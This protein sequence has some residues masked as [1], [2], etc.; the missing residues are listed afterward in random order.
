MNQPDNTTSLSQQAGRALTMLDGETTP[1]RS[2]QRSTLWVRALERL[3][4]GEAP[5]TP[6]E[7]RIARFL[8]LLQAS[9]VA[10]P[11]ADEQAEPAVVIGR[12]ASPD[13][14]SGP[15]GLWRE[16]T[17]F[18]RDERDW[19][20]QHIATLDE[21][22]D[23]VLRQLADP[24]QPMAAQTRGLV[25]GHIQ[26]GKTAHFTGLIAKAVDSGYRLVIVLTGALNLRRFQVQ[27]E[28]E[29][30]LWRG[31][32]SSG[33]GSA[34]AHPRDVA[35]RL[36][37]GVMRVTTLD[38]DYRATDGGPSPWEFIKTDPDQPLYAPRNLEH[39]PVRLLAVKKNAAVLSKIM[40]DLQ[41]SEC[42]LPELPALVIDD[43][44]TGAVPLAG[45]KD[46]G[47]CGAD[48][49]L[50]ELIALLPR[51]QY[52]KFSSTPFVR[53]LLDPGAEEELFPRDYVVCLPQP[54]AEPSSQKTNRA[55]LRVSELP[56]FWAHDPGTLIETEGQGS[57]AFELLGQ[58]VDMFVLT[59]ALKLYRQ[60][61]GP[62]VYR[63]H[64][65]LVH[66]GDRLVDQHQILGRL[67][68]QWDPAAF[69]R[70]DSRARLK[71]LF[72]RDILKQTTASLEGHHTPEAFEDL[73]PYIRAA[74]GRM[75]RAPQL[76]TGSD[77]GWRALQEDFE[78]REVW[79]IVIAG[80]KIARELSPAGLTVTF[81]YAQGSRAAN[82][83]MLNQWFGDLPGY[84]DLVR[85]YLGHSSD[86]AELVQQAGWALD[87]ARAEETFRAQLREISVDS[88]NSPLKPA[89]LPALAAQHLP[90]R[91][92]TRR[93]RLFNAE[94]VEIRSP[95]R[96]VE[97]LARPARAA[98]RAHNARVWGPLQQM[99]CDDV[100]SLVSS[101]FGTRQADAGFQA[102]AGVV[103]H[104]QLLDVFERL[105]WQRPE[106]FRPYLQYLRSLR[107]KLDDWAVFWPQETAENTLA[108]TQDSAMSSHIAPRRSELLA[109]PIQ[110]SRRHRRLGE[111]IVGMDRLGETSVP[112]RGVLFLY[113]MAETNLSR[114]QRTVRPEEF[115]MGVSY[116]VPD[117]GSS[118]IVRFK[119]RN[120]AQA[121][122]PILAL[123]R[124]QKECI[125]PS[126]LSA[127]V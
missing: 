71:A 50:A 64:T 54:A 124:R 122:A 21:G 98:D 2:D 4:A 48:G 10:R 123:T 51:A 55:P 80:T 11:A 27:Q 14:P 92:R 37:P 70:A 109:A 63:H 113:P 17:R 116:L 73:L 39:T 78:H 38:H 40:R 59:G 34:T 120:A 49:R 5:A 16:Y 41:A 13:R 108:G 97:H 85:F 69:H 56:S 33:S 20:E 45:G 61:T 94:L 77:E 99:L 90:W 81:A 12:P 96:W 7:D 126:P 46:T 32:S 68:R 84:R 47:N 74:V 66:G 19:A 3:S 65:M 89:Q 35:A 127:A 9:S 25:V 103:T 87:L 121:E 91:T 15:D 67:H 23:S 95:G 28:L 18:L 57:T 75:T 88:T 24:R 22:S 119:V 31:E 93:N 86:K 53:A 30:A 72:E 44:D 115:V 101:D 1:A 112:R 106:T 58:A 82:R 6:A 110:E 62:Y 43:E 125:A 105:R 107:G 29:R 76:I 83:L 36:R 100:T 42:P 8:E 52:V 102:R 26:S 111:M 118:Q 79:G 117:D 114:A 60:Q 104:A